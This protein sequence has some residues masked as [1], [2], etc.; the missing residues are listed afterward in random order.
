MKTPEHTWGKLHS[1][2]GAE[3]CGQRG[4]SASTS[5][6]TEEQLH[7]LPHRSWNGMWWIPQAKAY[8]WSTPV[9]SL[10]TAWARQS[11]LV[12][13]H[14]N[15]NDRPGRQ[16]PQVCGA[17]VWKEL[18]GVLR[19]KGEMLFCWHPVLL[20]WEPAGW[21]ENLLGCLWEAC[22]TPAAG[23]QRSFFSCFGASHILMTVFPGLCSYSVCASLPQNSTSVNSIVSWQMLKGFS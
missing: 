20:I 2:G 10:R 19:G 3:R 14:R 9:K 13:C 8:F 12:Q 16:L 22:G 1:F 5:P 7:Q 4:P 23:Y 17:H 15:D 21:W 6:Q 18:I 11:F